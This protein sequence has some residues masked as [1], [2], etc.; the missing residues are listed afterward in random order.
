MNNPHLISKIRA[1][2]N[3][4]GVSQRELASLIGKKETE[5][6]RWMSGR[7]GISRKNIQL[8]AQV[9]DEPSISTEYETEKMNRQQKNYAIILAGGIGSR[10][11]ANVPKQFVEILGKP[12]LAYTIEAYQNHPDI[13]GIEIVCVK[14][15]EDTLKTLVSKYNLTKVKW[16]CQGGATFQDSVYNGVRNLEGKIDRN[17]IVM[18]HYGA[19]PFTSEEIITDAIR[20]CREHGSSVSVTPCFQLIGSNDG[21]GQSKTWV[22]RD[23]YVQLA[24]PQSFRFQYICDIYEEAIE[25]NLLSKVEPHTTSLMYLMGKTLYLSYG[26]QSNIK[27]TTKEDLD[28]F[29]GYVLMKLNRAGKIK[30]NK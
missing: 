9:L 14:N 2:L 8:I 18:V 4:K 15:Y 17:D 22:D 28:M 6:S 7:V 3:N 12:V 5:V 21:N 1:I 29:E 25:R 30:I 10:V 20:V 16:I 11:G 27:I 19:A 26:D 13:D 23:K 24:C